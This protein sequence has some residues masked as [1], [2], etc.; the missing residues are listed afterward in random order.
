M[1]VCVYVLTVRKSFALGIKKTPEEA[2]Y[3]LSNADWALSELQF[4]TEFIHK[5]THTHTSLL[6]FKYVSIGKS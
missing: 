1:C 2:V 5:H 3:L 4:W 6:S